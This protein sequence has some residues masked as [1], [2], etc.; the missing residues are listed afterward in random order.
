[1]ATDLPD[2]AQSVDGA[3]RKPMVRI[4]EE[5]R[6]LL[7]LTGDPLDA[8]ITLRSAIARGLVDSIGNSLSGSVTYVNTFPG[9]SVP[10]PGA[11]PDLTP[12]PTVT[13]LTAAG[14]FT[15]VIVEWAAATYSAGHGHQKTNLYAVKKPVGS[16]DLPTFT[17]ATRVYEATGALTI[18]SLP[19]ELNTRWHIWAKYETKDGVESTSPA[20]G[21]NGV[22]CETGQ[23][24][25]QLLEVLTG[26]ITADQ[27]YVDLG[28]RIDLI[29]QLERY[30]QSAAQ[31]TLQALLAAHKAGANAQKG[32]AI[33]QNELTT[34]VNED[35]SAEAA[36]RSLLGAALRDTQATLT[37]EQTV[38][39]DADDAIAQD[40]TILDAQVN[41]ATT[42]L[43]V[44]RATL[45][46]EQTA[47]ATADSALASDITTLSATVGTNTAAI[48][49]EATARATADGS[50]FAQYTVKLDVNGYVSG[51]GLASTSTGAAPFS[52]FIIRADSFAISAPSGPGISP[53]TPFIVRTT[54]ST[55]NGVSIPI[56]VFMDA[57]YIVN[58]SALYGRFGTLIAD[59]L[60]AGQID[61]AHLTLGDGTIGGNLKSA[62]FV[63]GVSGWLL[64]PAGYL[65]ASN[66]VIRGASYTGAIFAG[67]GTIGGITIG[68]H[69]LRS[70]NYVPSTSGFRIN[71]DGTVEIYSLT[72][73]GNITANSLSAATG[74]LGALSVDDLLTLSSTGMLRGGQSAYGVGNGFSL[75]YSG[76][77]YKFYIGDP[78]GPHMEWDGTDLKINTAT[79]EAFSASI[80]GGAINAGASGFG[81]AAGIVHYADRTIAVTGGKAPYTYIWLISNGGNTQ[82][83]L[84]SIWVSSGT[85]ENATVSI[86]GT[87][88]NVTNFARLVCLVK[89]SNGRT[90]TASVS[91]QGRHQSGTIGG[92]GGDAP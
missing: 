41:D 39:A 45:L 54:T 15:Q 61:A 10:D 32:I 21:A 65:E 29:E 86:A 80:T 71:D 75:G 40:L 83:L 92:G 58:V 12:P 57:A 59:S 19:S 37:S 4:R 49:T 9:Y 87:G 48:S 82:G 50:L 35:V 3:V 43:P 2:V 90:T 68:L 55:E 36:Q 70:T 53:A 60:A 77:A 88:D 31:T 74:T 16:P 22:I 17:D 56:G 42:G 11:A 91:V 84:S 44:T 5:L 73:R 30:Q 38:R 6:R 85:T 47:R 69:D 18:A 89:D 1:M 76:G 78:S 63:A 8:A 13:G 64:T 67:S 62:N 33:A 72:A 79:F 52:T 26:S 14:G 25:V 34:K 66:V 20:G 81:L 46:T 24:I 28:T 51:Y 23:D 7:G 27:L